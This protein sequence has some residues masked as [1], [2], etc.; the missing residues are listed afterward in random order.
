MKRGTR[1]LFELLTATVLLVGACSK[2][3]EGESRRWE[4]SST[5]LSELAATYPG[6][7]PVIEARRSAAAKIHDAAAGLEGDAK[8]AR[9]S[10]ANAALMEGF[11]DDLDVLQG[12]LKKLR[13]S[14]VEVA[15]KASEETRLAARVATEDAQRALDHADVT[16]QSG[17][18]DEAAAAVVLRK[19]RSDL[20]TAQ[21]ALDK[22]LAIDKAKQTKAAD[23][24]KSEVSKKAGDEAAAAAQAAPWKCSYCSTENP[25]DETS[26][27]SCGAPKGDA[28]ARPATK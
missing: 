9:L 20:D 25:H 12:K 5:Q 17:A 8:I 24:Q 16:L 19:L 28:K 10:E 15:A 14:R 21:S 1:V 23:A 22:V 13:E 7:R 27:K 18:T 2:S 3:V 26:C 11:V 4:T 6:F